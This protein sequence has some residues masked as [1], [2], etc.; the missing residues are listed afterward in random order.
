MDDMVNRTLKKK[1]TTTAEDIMKLSKSDSVTMALKKSLQTPENGSQF[2]RDYK[3]LKADHAG[4]LEYLLQTVRTEKVIQKIFKSNLETDILIDMIE[5][6]SSAI[7][8]P[9]DPSV[10]NLA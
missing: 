1:T 8:S 7:P 4:K 5:V 6:F 10:K 3:S 2:E 9:E